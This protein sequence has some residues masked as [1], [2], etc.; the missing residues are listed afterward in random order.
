M[1]DFNKDGLLQE[2][3]EHD[4]LVIDLQ[5]FLD[6]HPTDKSAIERFNSA[7]EQ[8]RKLHSEYAKKYGPL[9]RA[10]ESNSGEHYS[11]VTPVWPWQNEYLK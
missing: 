3:M 2:I 1:K 6:T 11:W 9:S 4:F 8:S 5:L 7:V 10:D